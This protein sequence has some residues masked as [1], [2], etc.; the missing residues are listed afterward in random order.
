MPTPENLE[1]AVHELRASG[2]V[3]MPTETVYGLACRATDPAAVAKVFVAKGRPAENPLIVHV[4]TPEMAEEVAFVDERARALM[5]AFWP[6]P[7]TLVLP[8]KE[9]VPDAVAAGL[10][11]VA[12]RRPDHPVALALIEGVGPIA[13]P[14]ANRFS[15]LS[16][17]RAEDVDPALGD[18]LILDGGPSRIGIES[19]IIDLAD[20]EGPRLLRSGQ[21]SRR[22]VEGVLGV[23]LLDRQPNAP[24]V[25]PGAYERHYAPLT[26]VRLAESLTEADAGLTLGPSANFRQIAMPSDPRGYA[27]ALY[28][29]LAELDTLGLGEIVVQVPPRTP[30]WEP[31]H[32]RLRRATGE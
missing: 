7:L 13:A 14:S 30:E 4:A 8:R 23:A 17:T 27:A 18:F 28:R 32:D 6:G 25:A 15:R 12:V 20:P 21:I 10:P 19:T 11:T 3:V 1:R 31:I 24:I 9:G 29:S 2:V 5:E 16:P 22:E 26:P